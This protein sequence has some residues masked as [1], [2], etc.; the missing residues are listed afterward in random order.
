GVA[1]LV[2]AG[3]A[4]AYVAMPQSA[5]VVVAPLP[6]APL[7]PA[8]APAVVDA[9]AQ[10]AVVEP[11]PA[12]PPVAPEPRDNPP[13]TGFQLHR[14]GKNLPRHHVNRAA[15]LRRIDQLELRYRQR[16]PGDE[17]EA[18]SGN[19]LLANARKIAERGDDDAL[20]RLPAKL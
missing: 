10:L 6:L 5:E 1:A 17:R 18:Q 2:I 14:D 4:V 11:P 16:E 9:G 15:L 3:A 20:K 19:I 7:P 12:P 13:E 8:P